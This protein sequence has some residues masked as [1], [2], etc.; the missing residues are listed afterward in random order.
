MGREGK[1]VFVA[2]ANGRRDGQQTDSSQSKSHSKT[3]LASDSTL[4]SSS[5]GI[6]ICKSAVYVKTETEG[7]DHPMNMNVP[8]ERRNECDRDRQPR[9]G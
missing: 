8:S 2:S 6:P 7:I 1:F 3:T 4:I 5:N 9:F